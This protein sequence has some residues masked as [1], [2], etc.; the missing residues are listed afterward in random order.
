[1]GV[2]VEREGVIRRDYQTA[3]NVPKA[4]RNSPETSVSNRYYLADARFL[5]GLEGDEVLLK[6]ISNA[7]QNPVWPI[8][9]GRKA[10]VPSSPLVIDGLRD[11]PLEVALRNHPW[12]SREGEEVPARLRLIVECNANEGVERMD[13]PLSFSDRMFSPRFVKSEYL[14]T[15]G[16]TM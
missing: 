10:F 16:G 5:V 11:E 14:D 3:E 2:R 15:P 4:N 9:L 6:S 7:L 8:Y 13:V 12:L 1:M